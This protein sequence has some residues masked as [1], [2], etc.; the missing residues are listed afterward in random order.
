[1][2]TNLLKGHS[3][4][5]ILLGAKY[6][7]EISPTHG[8]HTVDVTSC[9]CSIFRNIL[10]LWIKSL[11]SLG[12]FIKKRQKSV[13]HAAPTCYIHAVWS[14]HVTRHDAL[15]KTVL[16]GTLVARGGTS[17]RTKEWTRRPVKKDL[18]STKRDLSGEPRLSMFSPPYPTPVDEKITDSI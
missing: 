18:L 6:P 16:Q 2:S 7:S 10:N 8:G 4:S 9:L 13:M 17:L 1:M 3:K 14:D 15:T 12:F 5:S 11:N